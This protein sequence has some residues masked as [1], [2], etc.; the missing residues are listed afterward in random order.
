MTSEPDTDS[1]IERYEALK[2][3]EFSSLGRM[4]LQQRLD[5]GQDL[6]LELY[7]CHRS[8]SRRLVLVFE[9]VRDLRFS[10]GTWGTIPIYL[11]ITSIR[12]DQWEGANYKVS[13]YEHLDFSFYCQA[14]S[15]DLTESQ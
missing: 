8:A 13:D 11:Q 4:E 6:T 9:N 14:F 7:S 1:A 3:T 10:P 12:R 15:A 5:A 2:P